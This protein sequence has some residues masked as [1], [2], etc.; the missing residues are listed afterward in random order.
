MTANNPVAIVRSFGKQQEEAAE[1]AEQAAE[2]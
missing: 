1:L 2:K